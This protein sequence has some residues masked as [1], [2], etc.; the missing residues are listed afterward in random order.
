MRIPCPFCGERGNEEFTVLG[1]M[2]GP[3]PAPDA[4]IEAWHDHVHLRDNP[5]GALRELW[6]HS[7]GCRAWLL[8]ER[9]T[10]SHAVLSVEPVRG[11]A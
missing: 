10:R 7:M 11:A 6:H 9:D 3:R 4:P 8:V 2:P 1:A 5:A